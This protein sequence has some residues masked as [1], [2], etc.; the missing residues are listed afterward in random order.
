[1][2]TPRLRPDRR[3]RVIASIPKTHHVEHELRE[4][5]YRIR[6]LAELL[7]LCRLVDGTEGCRIVRG[8]S[9]DKA[10]LSKRRK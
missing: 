8:Q 6:V 10:T 7:D 5:S 1:M 9:P 2:N 3:S 4:L